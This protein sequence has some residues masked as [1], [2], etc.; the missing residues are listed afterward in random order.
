MRLTN[1]MTETGAHELLE[2]DYGSPL[3]V[4]GTGNLN[5]AQGKML[6]VNPPVGTSTYYWL[7]LLFSKDTPTL[8]MTGKA[9]KFTRRMLWLYKYN[10]GYGNRAF[11]NYIEL[12]NYISADTYLLVYW[13]WNSGTTT[14][15]P[16]TIFFCWSHAGTQTWFWNQ[17]VTPWLTNALNDVES[18]FIIAKAESGKYSVRPFFSINKTVYAFGND[19]DVAM[20]NTSSAYEHM[21]TY[22]VYESES[23]NSGRIMW[24]YL[25]GSE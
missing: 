11:D 12:N 19:V 8:N 10:T 14:D 23:Y 15:T 1:W 22:L 21:L 6:V 25:G 13:K 24:V 4:L 9:I 17:S 16:S 5:P 7:R 2:S 20:I 3:H 18:G